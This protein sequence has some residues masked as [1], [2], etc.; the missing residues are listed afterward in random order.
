MTRVLTLRLD[1]ALLNQAEQR[2]AEL[3]LDRS[4]YVRGLIAADVGAAPRR[5]RRRFASEDLA[6]AFLGDG[7]AASAAVV[8]E[9]LK[10][11][12]GR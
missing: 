5:A 12:A 9:A 11:R 1:A 2:A 3:G 8:R 4:G 6:G 7:R 10:R